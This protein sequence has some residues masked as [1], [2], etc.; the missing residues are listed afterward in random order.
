[1]LKNKYYICTILLDGYS[2]GL[3]TKNHEH[4][5]RSAKQS[6]IEVHFTESAKC[7]IKQDV[8]LA[9]GANKSKFINM[10][11]KNL[12]RTGNKVAEYEED[13][14]TH[15]VRCTLELATI[16]VQVNVVAVDTDVAL[17]LLYHWNVTMTDITIAFQRTKASKAF[18]ITSSINSHSGLLNPYLFVLHAWSGCNTMSAIH[19]KGKTSLLKNIETSL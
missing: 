2:H 4:I 18:S 5:R 1:M 6:K 13:T 3:S 15:I 8:F 19:M 12:W 14:D 11:L 10:L 9:N 7:S 16:G 17:L